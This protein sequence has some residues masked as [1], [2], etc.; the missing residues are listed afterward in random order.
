MIKSKSSESK[1]YEVALIDEEEKKSSCSESDDVPSSFSSSSDP[2]SYTSSKVSVNKDFLKA[3][4][5][6]TQEILRSSGRANAIK[7]RS[8]INSIRDTIIP[9]KYQGKK[10]N[11]RKTK[12]FFANNA[13][14]AMLNEL[15]SESCFY[16][17]IISCLCIPLYSQKQLNEQLKKS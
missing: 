4:A 5:D 15:K 3:D 7:R 6:K 14:T 10:I 8:N 17:I 16:C 13:F 12:S 9:D 11:K 2:D 1:E